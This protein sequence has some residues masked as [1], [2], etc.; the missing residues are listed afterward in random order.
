MQACSPVYSPVGAALRQWA[1]RAMDIILHIGAHRTG[2]T[3]FQR[4]M[5]SSEDAL[6]E[7]GVRFWGPSRTRKG[8]FTGIYAHLDDHRATEAPDPTIAECLAQEKAGAVQKL[9]VSDENM[10]GSVRRNIREG[11]LYP[12]AGRHVAGFAKAFGGDV[13]T[14]LVSVR[15]LDTYWCSALAY[16]VERG[17]PVMDRQGRHALAQDRRGWR[18][19]IAEIARA[20]PNVRVKVACFETY[21]GRPDS[22]LHD[23]CGF[24]APLCEDRKPVNPSPQLPDLRR[25]LHAKGQDT[26]TLPFGMGRWNPFS[27][28]E[29]AALRETYAD[30]MMWLMA[31]A[32]GLATLIEDRSRTKA[33]PNLLS[34]AH[35]KGQFDEFEERRMARPGNG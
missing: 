22:L 24:G 18:D 14:L 23:A 34:A 8:L 13:S 21:K 15:S 5:R 27:N 6:S 28:E 4:Y 12:D 33:G 31:G 30:D 20:L 11:Q 19:V 9:V 32:D 26:K 35:E 10:M 29:H 17:I 25:A 7:Q 1:A 2:T 16:G 3:H